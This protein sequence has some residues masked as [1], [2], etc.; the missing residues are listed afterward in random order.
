MEEGVEAVVAPDA[1]WGQRGSGGGRGAD[2]GI[3][4]DGTEFGS[5]ATTAGGDER[6]ETVD[7]R[8]GWRTGLVSGVGVV[9]REVGK[10]SGQVVAAGGAGKWIEGAAACVVD[11]EG[12]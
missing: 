7:G 2:H 4:C 11:E 10:W 1:P 6:A 9:G 3:V 8:F 12:V 5:G